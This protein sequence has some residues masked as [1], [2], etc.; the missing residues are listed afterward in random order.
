MLLM[1]VPCILMMLIVFLAI[2]ADGEEAGAVAGAAADG[3]AAG[4]AAGVAVDGVAA[5]AA[6]DGVVDGAT[7]DGVAAVGV[8]GDKDKMFLSQ[9]HKF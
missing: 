6:A 5:G 3:V 4:A 7:V 8:T 9:N 1:P 2:G